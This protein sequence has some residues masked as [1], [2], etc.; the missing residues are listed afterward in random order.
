MSWWERMAT[1][2]ARGQK[3]VW[4]V[5]KRQHDKMTKYKNTGRQITKNKETKNQKGRMA[6]APARGQKHAFTTLSLEQSLLEMM[7]HQM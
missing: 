1:A 7:T 2:P 4:S 6:T 3:H 5:T